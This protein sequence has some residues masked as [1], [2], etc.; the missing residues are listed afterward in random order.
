MQIAVRVEP[1]EMPEEFAARIRAAT[2]HAD[3]RVVR[4]QPLQEFPERY[5][6]H[7]LAGD[8]VVWMILAFRPDLSVHEVTETFLVSQL[9]GVEL[10][11][12]DALLRAE[13]AGAE[14]MVEC[15]VEV[16]WA[17]L[18]RLGLGG[19]AVPVEP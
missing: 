18:D 12:D 7:A 14:R 11:D 4:P 16:G 15:P 9:S 6:V 10:R 5:V 1:D 13:V 3:V 17:V 8:R 2:A 19:T